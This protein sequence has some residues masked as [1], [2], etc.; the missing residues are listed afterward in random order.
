M[1][2]LQGGWVWDWVDQA[3]RQPIVPDRNGR[4]LKVKPGD[5]TFWAFGGDFGPEGT[6]SDQNFCCNGLV[7]ADRTPHPGLAE[8]KK[9]YQNIQVSA[10]D[11]AKGQIKIKN[12]YFFT[13]LSDLVKGTWTVSADDKVIDS[14]TLD[15]LDIGPGDSNEATIPFKSIEPEPGVEYF[16]D[17]SFVLKDKQSWAPAGHE[18]AWEQFKLPVEKPAGVINSGQ[19]TS[20]KFSNRDNTIGVDGSNFS[21]TID[22]TTGFIS[23][24]RYKG[25]ELVAE[26]LAPDFWRAPT[27]NDR[28][29]NMSRRC[30]I[31]KTAMQSWK[32]QNVTVTRLSPQVVQVSVVSRIEDVQGDYK[33]NYKIYGDGTIRI[34][35]EGQAGA[36][37]LPEIPRFGMRM[38]MPKGFETIRWFGRGPQ[39]TYWDRC[40]ARVD[41][42]E[43]T[44]DEQ[45]FDYSEP[46]ESGNKADVRWVALT[47]DKG[48]GLLAIGMPH[49]SVNA[50]H[51]T[52]EDLEGPEHI[53]QVQRRDNIYLNLDYRQMGVGGD[54]SWGART[55]PEFTLPG[56][57]KYSYSFV[58]R[59]YDLSMGQVQ[60]IARMPVPN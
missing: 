20:L 56:N 21:V 46:T 5:K 59:P 4:F 38:A 11:L 9:I 55:H 17:L 39:E 35:A 47:N 15:S 34:D 12:G 30:G 50:L 23:L 53:Y 42:Y 31:W 41:L 27:D 58:L 60:Q 10:V 25:T 40:D 36:D 19:M 24:M 13:T 49:L 16:L 52:A 48:V 44:V 32:P 37:R 7:S 51:Y 57:E 29:N 26:P 28:G 43:G 45:Y 2:Y 6:P 18:I 14:G 33:L 22:K 3:L 8:I 1:P 54:D